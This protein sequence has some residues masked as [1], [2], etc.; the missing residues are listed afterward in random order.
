MKLTRP[1]VGT[2]LS[3]GSPAIAELAALCGFDWVLIDFEHG[4]GT[5]ATVPDQL[6]ALRGC[7]EIA[8]TRRFMPN[9]APESP[10]VLWSL[11]PLSE[12]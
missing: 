5:E 1:S 2:W 11:V 6:R 8:V 12:A 10:F 3:T 4:S 9:T 7:N